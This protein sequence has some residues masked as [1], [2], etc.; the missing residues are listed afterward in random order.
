MRIKRTVKRN[1]KI[2]WRP[3]RGLKIW[4][5]VYSILLVCMTVFVLL[6]AFVIPSNI[7]QT[8]TAEVSG[9]NAGGA[10]ENDESG[11]G[12]AVITDSSYKDDKISISITTK[13]VENTTVYIADVQLADASC[14]K[15][16]LAGGVFGRNVTETTSSIAE[17]NGAIFA[18]NG[19][20]YGFRSDGYVMRNGYLYR[21]TSAGSDQ[22]DL[23][24]YG[25]GTMDVVR[26]S[27]TS[28]Q[29]L[30]D[31][32]AQQIFSFGPGLI[33]DGTITV[34]A[35]S[36]VERSQVTNPR[37]AIGM[38]EPLH[39]MM[40]VS[41]GRTSESTG[42]SLLQL[43]EVMQDLGCT[44]AYNLDGGGSS[45][46]WFNGQVLNKPTTYGRVIE[47]R[48]LSDILYISD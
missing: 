33:E 14:L 10:Q 37:T 21:T 20:Y 9:E 18:I 17:E 3:R 39:Y 12:E 23:V 30:A 43:A 28:A 1:K 5:I 47:E 31:N 48:A 42:L 19:D 41:D 44:E 2:K 46:M 11:S 13:R 32:G 22:E 26:E 8:N 40:V 27:D 15:T 16:G 29:E 45:T 7:V 35:N 4:I 6:D 36:E 34:N 38:I 24:I 25:D